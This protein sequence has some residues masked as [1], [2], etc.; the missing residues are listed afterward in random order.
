M[1]RTHKLDADTVH[2]AWDNAIAPRLTIDAGD[3]V[4]FQTRDAADG[5]YSQDSTAADVASRGPFTG[6]PLTG[7]VHV[8]DAAP[9]DVLVVGVLDMQLASPFG[10]TAVRP[11]RGLLPEAE[12]PGSYLQI[13]D[14]SDGR[15]GRMR[16][17]HDIAVPLAPFPGIMGTA[18]AEPGAH[19][20]MPPR[21]NGGNM[22]N[23]HLTVGA[24]L[25]LPVLVEGALFSTGDAHAAQGDGEVCVT[26]VETWSELTLKFDLLQGKDFAE[27]RLRTAGPLCQ[28]TNLGPYFATTAQ[29]PDLYASAQQAT[30]YM[31]EHL[32]TERGLSWFEAYALC[33]VAVD[34]KISEI[35]D[36][37]NWLVSAFLPECVFVE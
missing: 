4:I 5:Y 14:L 24:T 33:S 19:S 10:W 1:S 17:R 3:S 28:G 37:P 15:L 30:R 31:I 2:Y 27:P 8:R 7:P 6:H 21:Q 18:L 26:A 29:G 35:V 22:D 12:V 13:W 20:T 16:Q 36:V 11:G 9:G 23:K 32:M 34:L 25:Y